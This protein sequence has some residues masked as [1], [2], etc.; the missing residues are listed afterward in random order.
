MLTMSGTHCHDLGCDVYNW[1]LEDKTRIMQAF[2]YLK[3]IAA[4]G[5]CLL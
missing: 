5:Q 3:Y 4:L 2:C 1:D